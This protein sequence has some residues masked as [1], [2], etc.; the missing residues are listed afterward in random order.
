MGGVVEDVLGEEGEA[1]VLHTFQKD[2]EL[3]EEVGPV[4][5]AGH[6]R[7]LY[8]TG[9]YTTSLKDQPGRAE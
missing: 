1:G 9:I 8:S 4:G 3:L 5:M 6:L 7:Y 2:D